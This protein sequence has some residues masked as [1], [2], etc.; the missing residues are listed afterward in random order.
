M[1]S[2]YPKFVYHPEKEAVIVESAEAHEALGAE[3]AEVPFETEA[4]SEDAPKKRTRKKA[5]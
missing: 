3:W 2:C 1:E 5:E 4:E